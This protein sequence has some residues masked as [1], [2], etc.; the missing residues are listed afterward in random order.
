MEKEEILEFVKE[1]MELHKKSEYT[2]ADISKLHPFEGNPSEATEAGTEMLRESILGQGLVEDVI[3]YRHEKK[4]LIIAGHKRVE[5]YKDLG[6]KKVPAKIYPFRSYKHAVLY[7]IASNRI[8][9]LAKTDFP[10]LKEC[11]DY[12]D[13]GSISLVLS[14]YSKR[15]Q[16]SMIDWQNYPED[17]F[18]FIDQGDRRAIT[19]RCDSDEEFAQVKR[20]LGIGDKKINTI[21]GSALLEIL[22]MAKPGGG[23]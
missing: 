4:L 11:L 15:V 12:C 9:Q 2:I 19:I 16:E 21:K 20:E 5:I 22:E 13:D 17:G 8:A 14:G 3:L 18:E 23:L 7:C 10:K 1:T 6:V